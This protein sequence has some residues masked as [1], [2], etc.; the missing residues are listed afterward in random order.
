M[1]WY[2]GGKVRLGVLFDDI[3]RMTRQYCELVGLKYFLCKG[4]SRDLEAN[5][6]TL[7]VSMKDTRKGV[8]M[9]EKYMWPGG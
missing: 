9:F 1:D 6:P 3:L 8:E 7:N 5:I 2:N 4:N